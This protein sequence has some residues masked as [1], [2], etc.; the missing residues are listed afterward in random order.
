MCQIN[1]ALHSPVWPFLLSEISYHQTNS[2]HQFGASTLCPSYASGLS[3]HNGQSQLTRW[4]GRHRTT[5]QWGRSY[6]NVLF[7]IQL[8]N[9]IIKYEW[10]KSD[11]LNDCRKAT[12]GALRLPKKLHF[13][14]NL[15]APNPLNSARNAQKFALHMWVS[16]PTQGHSFSGP[17]PSFLSL[18]LSSRFPWGSPVL[19]AEL[20]VSYGFKQ[21]LL[22][23]PMDLNHSWGCFIHYSTNIHQTLDVQRWKALVPVS[24]IASSTLGRTTD[25]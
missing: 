9:S 21:F 1:P 22:M 15:R 7:V 16:I 4:E 3:A 20:L 18:P 12:R 10:Q 8:N 19:L 2:T 25:I 23:C 6:W 5:K 14:T 13:S 11:P 24:H 17:S